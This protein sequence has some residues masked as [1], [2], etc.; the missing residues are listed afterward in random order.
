MDTKAILLRDLQA[1]V[2]RQD[3]NGKGQ[4]SRRYENTQAREFCRYL[5]DGCGKKLS[6]LLQALLQT[7]HIQSFED[8]AYT[9]T[10]RLE[11]INPAYPDFESKFFMLFD[12]DSTKGTKTDEFR[13]FT[14]NEMEKFSGHWHEFFLKENIIWCGWITECFHELKKQKKYGD[15]QQDMFYYILNALP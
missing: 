11:K 15:P 2:D 8:R 13:T 7:R 12:A 14:N 10:Q 6:G 4:V 9:I 1:F 5:Y 3:P